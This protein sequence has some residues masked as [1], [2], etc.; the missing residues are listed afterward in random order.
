MYLRRPP[1]RLRRAA[2]ITVLLIIIGVTL[3]VVALGPLD[4]VQSTFFVLCGPSAPPG[5]TNIYPNGVT[6]DLSWTVASPAGALGS[7]QV[8]PSSTGTWNDAYTGNGADGS[9]QFSANGGAYLFSCST[10][11]YPYNGSIAVSTSYWGPW[12]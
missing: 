7:L 12:L 11:T 4:H 8:Y 1:G 3:L 10:T 2:A 6:V 9:G 5:S